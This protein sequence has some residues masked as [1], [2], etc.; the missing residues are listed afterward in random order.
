V[1]PF[2]QMTDE[3]KQQVQQ[4]QAEAAQ[5]PPQPDA[6]TL[7][8]LAEQEKAKADTDDVI[9]KGEIAQS[10]ESRANFQAEQDAANDATKLEQQQQTL[11]FN[12][13]IALQQQTLAQNKQLIDA[14]NKQAASLKLLREAMGVDSFTGPGTSIAF[15][16]QARQ[17]ID[18]Q[19][20]A[21]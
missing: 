6:A 21:S 4:A 9:L 16:E 2:E 13:F 11:D 5:N 8:A 17:V 12:Q 10:V 20:D 18:A 3:E 14:V 19:E 15:I 1:I 7:L